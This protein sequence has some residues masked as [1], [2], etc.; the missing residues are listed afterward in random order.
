[1]A[2]ITHIAGHSERRY[3]SHWLDR[4]VARF[5]KRSNQVSLFSPDPYLGPKLPYTLNPWDSTTFAY[6]IPPAQFPKLE[7]LEVITADDRRWFCPRRDIERVRTRD[8]M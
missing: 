5:V 3:K 2:K 8:M 4:L 7:T 1:M 6:K